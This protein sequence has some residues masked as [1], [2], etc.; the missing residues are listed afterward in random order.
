MHTADRQELRAEALAKGEAAAGE[1]SPGVLARPS[2]EHLDAAAKFQLALRRQRS[3]QLP[4]SSGPAPAAVPSSHPFLGR[5]SP[6]VKTEVR[7]RT[8]FCFAV[9]SMSAHQ[10]P[11]RADHVAV[12]RPGDGCQTLS[13]AP[14]GAVPRQLVSDTSTGTAIQRP[15][16]QLSADASVSGG[17]EP[18]VPAPV[19]LTDDCRS[20][21][22]HI[23]RRAIRTW[24][25]DI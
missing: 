5:H 1:G 19:S 25:P 14:Q 8:T 11:R 20:R 22:A 15:L 21:V 10:Q 16:N 18:Q 7:S 17:S 2:Q 9:L 13:C 24:M 23:G 4:A 6:T 3:G 12:K